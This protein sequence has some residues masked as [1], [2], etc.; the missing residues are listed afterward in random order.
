MQVE[1]TLAMAEEDHGRAI[2]GRFAA[3]NR[4]PA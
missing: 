1:L 4:P 3:G 2:Q